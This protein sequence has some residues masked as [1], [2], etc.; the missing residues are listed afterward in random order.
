MFD[1]F[2]LLLPSSRVLQ[3]FVTPAAIFAVG[4]LI[5]STFFQLA[6]GRYGL[7]ISSRSL[8]RPPVRGGD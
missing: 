8:F 1:W 2:Q 3:F 5:V 6:F 7:K 4:D